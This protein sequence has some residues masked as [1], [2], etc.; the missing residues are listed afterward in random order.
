MAITMD[1]RSARRPGRV[2][3]AAAAHAI[4][5]ARAF[6]AATRHSRLV[7][8]LRI[9]F[10]AAAAATLLVYALSAPPKRVPPAGNRRAVEGQSIRI[11]SLSQQFGDDDRTPRTFKF[12]Q[13]HRI[14]L[15]CPK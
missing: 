5:R 15:N 9:A 7:A 3:V 13:R 1:T 6:A 4:Q 11:R 12:G 10:P 2:P 14:A 8:V